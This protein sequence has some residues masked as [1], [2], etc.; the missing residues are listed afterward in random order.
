[1]KIFLGP[2]EHPNRKNFEN[3]C[4]GAWKPYVYPIFSNSA[5]FQA[6]LDK[7]RFGSGSKGM[8]IHYLNEWMT[9]RMFEVKCGLEKSRDWRRTIHYQGDTL[10]TLIQYNILKPHAQVS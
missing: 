1:M 3:F 5:K 4:L 7:S 10:K 9:P 2:R 6:I 8:C